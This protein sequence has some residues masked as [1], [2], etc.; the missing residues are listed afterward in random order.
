MPDLIALEWNRQRIRV[1]AGTVRG[2]D[3]RIDHLQTIILE[4]DEGDGATG[5]GDGGRTDWRSAP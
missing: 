3:C 2:H 1:V 4:K 5:P